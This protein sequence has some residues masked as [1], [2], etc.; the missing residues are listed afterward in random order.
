[1]SKGVKLARRRRGFTRLSGKR[2]VTLPLNVV[3]AMKLRPGDELRVGMEGDRVVL[4]REPSSAS[5]RLQAIRRVAG[6]LPG[7]WE[8][9]NLE[10]LRG[11]WR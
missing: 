1:M 6:S 3:E 4:T 2:Q 8:P 10:R 9:G 5:V 7:V 11:E